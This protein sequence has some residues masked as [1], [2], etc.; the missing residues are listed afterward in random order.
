VSAQVA[1]DRLQVDA[2]LLKFKSDCVACTAALLTDRQALQADD[3]RKD[4][5]LAPLFKTMRSDVQQMQV[6]LASDRLAESSAVLQDESAVVTE[7]EK[8]IADKGNKTAMASDKSQLLADR[9]QLQNDEIAG[10]NARVMTRENDYSKIF[11]DLQNIATA[12]QNESGVS[13]QVV[14]DVRKFITDRTNCMN[15]LEGDLN[16]LIAARTQLVTDLT[17]MQN[18]S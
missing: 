5:T 17:A 2:D 12:V 9:I 18:Q 3:V 6:Q 14:T 10:L 8:M 11:A 1:A 7:L 13:S 16:T 15:T 4:A